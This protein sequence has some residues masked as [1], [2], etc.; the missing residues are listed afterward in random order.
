[1]CVWLPLRNLTKAQGHLI[2]APILK[3]PHQHQSG[4]YLEELH[5]LR[6]CRPPWI[7]PFITCWHSCPALNVCTPWESDE[8]SETWWVTN[9]LRLCKRLAD[10]VPRREREAGHAL[11]CHAMPTAS[12]GRRHHLSAAVA[13]WPLSPEVADSR[14]KRNRPQQMEQL[15]SG[16]PIRALCPC[17]MSLTLVFL[18][19]QHFKTGPFSFGWRHKRERVK[20]KLTRP[21]SSL[22]LKFSKRAGTKRRTRLRANKSKAPPQKKSCCAPLQLP[23]P[24]SSLWNTLGP[25][26]EIKRSVPTNRNVCK[27]SACTKAICNFTKWQ[28]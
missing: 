19:W 20:E 13:A 22:R 9:Y 17:H 4:S 28:T 6:L 24:H 12:P 14:Q 25:K 10:C 7:K 2:M 15:Y 3:H 21:L 27:E 11:L 26:E 5:D 16:W 1:M 23:T 8:A 18:F